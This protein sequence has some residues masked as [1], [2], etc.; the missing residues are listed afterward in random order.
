MS[1]DRSDDNEIDARARDRRIALHEAAHLCVGRALG[2]QFGGATIEE[3]P[4]LGYSG[5]VWGPD[6]SPQSRFAG[7][8]TTS[9]VIEQLDEL[10]PR[11]GDTRDDVA[12]V[13]KHVHTR[14]V[15]LTAGSEAEL[16]HLGDAWEA[17]DDR[18]QEQ[19]LAAL[20]YSSPEA[21]ATFIEACRVEARA[22]LR[23]H[24]DVL[25]ALGAALIEHREIDGP[26][27]DQVISRAVTARQL[28]QEHQRRRRWADVIERA[29]TNANSF[30]ERCRG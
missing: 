21:Q 10:M 24:A 11:D 8:P 15:E 27:I 26:L 1:D 3:N 13:Y 9:S 5:L 7:Q 29:K 28:R 19:R 22:I 4:D 25:E 6:Y 14:V 23:R 17:T 12:D 30:T 16:L 20:I 2:A 18:N